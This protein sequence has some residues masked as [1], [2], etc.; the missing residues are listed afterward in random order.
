MEQLQQAM[1]GTTFQEDEVKYSL[2]IYDKEGVIIDDEIELQ[3][4]A[5]SYLS[6][7]HDDLKDFIWQKDGFGLTV[8]KGGEGQ[9]RHYLTGKTRYG[10]NVDDEWFIV[11]LLMRLTNT[12]KG[13]VVQVQDNDGEFML[14]EAAHYLPNWIDPDNAIN[15]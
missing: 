11:H 12:V 6:L 3:A 8:V 15:R 13:L 4:I 9:P 14:I 5:T 2:Y 7:L 1:E 10:D